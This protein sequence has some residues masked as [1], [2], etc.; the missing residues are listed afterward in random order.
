M[1]A[2]GNISIARAFLFLYNNFYRGAWIKILDISN[3]ALLKPR[4]LSPHTPF[5]VTRQ[6]AKPV[7]IDD[8]A[9]SVLYDFY[10]HPPFTTTESA[11]IQAALQQ[12]KLSK[13]RSLF[14]VDGD[15]R[16][17]GHVSARDILG[18][19]PAMLASHFGVKLSEV[20]VKMLM[21][22]YDEMVALQYNEL[23]NARVGHIARLFH[24]LGVNY[25]YVVEQNDM[26]GDLMRGI[27]SISRVS[28][29]LGENVMSDLASHSVAEMNQQI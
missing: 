1:Q 23:S 10:V 15:D 12:M 29:Q 4:H 7:L 6:D 28:Y 26:G 13:V 22:P 17:L 20:T 2:R 11:Q 8:P 3:Y 24:D 21:I 25:I 5:V 16:I 19:K 18:T 9:I 14:V 27:F